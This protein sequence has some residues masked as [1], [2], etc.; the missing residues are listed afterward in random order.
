LPADL[1]GPRGP[2]LPLPPDAAETPLATLFE[3]AAALTPD[4]AALD[5]GTRRLTYAEALHRVRRLAAAITEAVP[6]G[7]VVAV[8]MPVEA[9]LPLAILAA[10]ATGRI[11]ALVDIHGPPERRA[12]LIEA[13]GAAAVLTDTASA[14]GLPRGSAPLLD[15]GALAEATP[16]LPALPATDPFAPA[17]ILLTSGSTGQP[18]GIVN[19][20]AALAQRAGVH[21]AA[22]HIG[23]GDRLAPLSAPTSI[24]GLR[25]VLA[26]LVAG[27][28]L[29]LV[30]PRGQEPR[31]TLARLAAIRPTVVYAVPTLVRALLRLPGAG[32]AF[33]ALRVLRLGGEAIH[34]ADIAALRPLL[35]GDARIM[36]AYSSTETP[37]AHWFVPPGGADATPTVPGGHVAAGSRFRILGPDGAPVPD[38]QPGELVMR[39]RYVALGHWVRG[40]LVAGP[41]RPDPDDPLSRIFPTGDRARLLPD[42][43]LA[44]LGRLD[45]MVKI[46]GH[47]VE[48]R[49][50]EAALR[51]LDGVDD[52]AVIV[53]EAEHG[54]PQ[55]VGF[56]VPREGAAEG[57]VEAA[58]R[59]LRA[60][61]P[62][63]MQPA[64]LHVVE[65]VPMTAA[66]KPDRAALA[67]LDA[68]ALA[69]PAP[70]VGEIRPEVAWAVSRAW[71]RSF[72]RRSLAA[73]ESFE[74]AGG[75]S[76][77]LLR[78]AYDIEQRLGAFTFLPLDLFSPDMRPS[79]MAAAI[80]HAGAAAPPAPGRP[81]VHLLPGLNGDEPL[82]SLFRAD[83]ADRLL[84]V[85]PPYP[86]WREQRDATASL[87]ELADGMA[88]RIAAEVPDGPIRLAGYSFGGVVAA[89]AAARLVA[90]GRD[91]AFLGLL[92]TAG[93]RPDRPL[94]GAAL[95][96]AIGGQGVMRQALSE[97]R[98]EDL[99]GML[100]AETLTR[101]AFAPLLGLLRRLPRPP[102]PLRLRFARRAWLHSLLRAAA[103]REWLA[104]GTPPL[105]DGVKVVLFRSAERSELAPADLGWSARCARLEV[106][107]VP[108][109]HHGMFEAGNRAVLAARFAEAALQEL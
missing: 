91:V 74:A 106:I 24:A 61:L 12:T 109:S 101:P 96:R 108:G 78:L 99:I 15:A 45:G 89:A 1:N 41:M 33:A 28:C 55:L 17:F 58:R 59:R 66:A 6:A 38:G 85:T 103:A 10:V 3:R 67:R 100:A 88:A 32:R 104:R 18:K 93:M 76:L 73:D 77:A 46:A 51:G 60:A 23:P 75:D 42:G 5:D 84:A 14:N 11:A 71:R 57:L 54:R 20:Q 19:S 26:A 35:P 64:R 107:E 62:A 69:A 72:G 25:E 47:R 16:P 31:R 4:A 34:W 21:V 94:H 50:V 86:D 27:A 8:A 36:A 105:P 53:A 30:E 90:A 13:A 52:A 80:A 44:L 95:R 102:L 39:G 92:D 79:E 65:A 56:L 83:L 29:H 81:L 49:E 48:P 7:G 82:L 68:E 87:D 9:M 98:V 43:R 2:C 40:R 63:P 70:P 37:G 97:R 22:C